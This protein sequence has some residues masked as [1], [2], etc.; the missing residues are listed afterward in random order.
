MDV[1]AGQTLQGRR[2]KMWGV[3]RMGER[4]YGGRWRR[5]WS[6]LL[7]HL[8]LPLSG[9]FMHLERNAARSK[10]ARVWEVVDLRGERDVPISPMSCH[11]TCDTVK[12][13]MR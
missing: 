8:R 11:K 7:S 5:L 13:C 12:F 2:E 1:P 6:R 3:W 10:A 4:P 9:E